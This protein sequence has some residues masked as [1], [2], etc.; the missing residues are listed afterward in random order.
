MELTLFELHLD[1]ASFAANAPF[2]GSD[3]G[4]GSPFGSEEESVTQDEE[5]SSGPS[6]KAFV[7][8]LIFLVGIGLAVRRFMGGRGESDTDVD[9]PTAEP[10]TA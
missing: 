3:D 1:E 9:E 8:G 2:A 4:S 10:V 6:P 5:G 7:V